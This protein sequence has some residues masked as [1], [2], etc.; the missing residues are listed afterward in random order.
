MNGRS[1][2]SQCYNAVTLLIIKL[3]SPTN[4]K[5]NLVG[6]I[7]VVLRTETNVPC[8]ILCCC[9]MLEPTL[10][11][12]PMLCQRRK[13]RCGIWPSGQSRPWAVAPAR[14]Q[15]VHRKIAT[16]RTAVKY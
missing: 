7:M 12:R 5:S 9:D 3:A 15:K 13:N 8:I 1:I 2:L 10:E 11:R 4:Q 6:R 16:K 14:L